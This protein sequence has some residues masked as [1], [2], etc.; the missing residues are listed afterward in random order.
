MVALNFLFNSSCTQKNK[1][2]FQERFASLAA[3][4]I[5]V[6][7]YSPFLTKTVNYDQIA[8]ENRAICSGHEICHTNFTS[9]QLFVFSLW[10]F[11]WV[12]IF[13]IS[14]RNKVLTENIR[15][16]IFLW[17]QRQ[18]FRTNA[19]ITLRR[20]YNKMTLSKIPP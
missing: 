10:Q 4:V 3:R 2:P 14:S 5:F 12:A 11:S 7:W 9:T 6:S 19:C 18:I 16:Q 1:K 8:T 20:Q 15:Y 17:M 13:I